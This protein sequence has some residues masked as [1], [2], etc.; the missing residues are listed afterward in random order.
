MNT[1]YLQSIVLTLTL[2]TSL[3]VLTLAGTDVRV[4]AQGTFPDP[5]AGCPPATCV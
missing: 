1:R 3:L 4:G 5:N 2:F